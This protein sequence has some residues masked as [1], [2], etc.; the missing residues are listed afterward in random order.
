MPVWL[1]AFI[2][3]L[4]LSLTKRLWE[5]A[6]AEVKKE[7]AANLLEKFTKEVEEKRKQDF[8]LIDKLIASQ[9]KPL[10]TEQKDAIRKE[11][12]RLELELWN[13]RP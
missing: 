7:L 2:Q 11:R 5:R 6:S 10:T 4:L 8:A 13:T 3:D 9:G 12:A 1:S